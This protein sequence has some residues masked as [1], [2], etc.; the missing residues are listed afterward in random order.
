MK[1]NLCRLSGC[2]ASCCRG[3]YFEISYPE[4]KVLDWFPEAL[5]VEKFQL[6]DMSG[7]GVYY[8]ESNPGNCWVKI[9][10][11]CPNLGTDNNC[12]IYESRPPDCSRLK[13]GSETCLSF[14]KSVK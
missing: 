7:K 12:R 2:G 1:E 5:K 9:V 3:S 6:P 8:E 11:E 4:E 13:P 10:E 14:R